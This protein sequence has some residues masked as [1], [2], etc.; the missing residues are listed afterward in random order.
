M[1]IEDAIGMEVRLLRSDT[2]YTALHVIGVS[3][4]YHFRSLHTDIEPQITIADP[5]YANL[6]LLRI[7]VDDYKEIEKAL[8]DLWEQYDNER[9]MEISF[10]EESINNMYESDRAIRKV[11]LFFT[12]IGLM[13]SILGLIGL[14]SFTID[15][16]TKE[17][18]I[19]KL[20][21]AR[22]SDVLLLITT[23]FLKW[24]SVSF[25]IAAPIAYLLMIRWLNEFP[26]RIRL[27]WWLLLSGGLIALLVAF[28]T[29]GLQ[30][31]RAARANP[32]DSLRYE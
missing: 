32:A 31:H 6:V 26:Y 7:D 15:Q 21:G 8:L 30:S 4:D 28:M 29:I 11:I 14:T 9:P 2:T 18:G 19:R 10:L 27:H 3:K 20:M 5:F 24:I 17:I 16:K 25:L 12:V 23:Q 22:I 1:G 13:I